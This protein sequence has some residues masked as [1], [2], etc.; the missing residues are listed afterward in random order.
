[1]RNI[2]TT[3][4]LARFIPDDFEDYR[5]GGE[6]LRR[7]LTHAVMR[8]INIPEKWDINGEYRS[9]F[10][11]LFPVQCRFTPEHGNFYLT[12]CSP[13]EISPVWLL[14][15]VNSS[16]T[17]AAVLRSESVFNPDVLNHTVSLVASLDAQGYSHNDIINTLGM[18]GG[19]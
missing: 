12:L 2:I 6:E 16:G 11:G 15:F 18:E 10:G 19:L 4:D 13:G 14:V 3:D 17:P 7:D 1:M 5:A 8:D 9:E